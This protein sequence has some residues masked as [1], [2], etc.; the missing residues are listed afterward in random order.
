MCC[1]NAILAPGV[2]SIFCT[3]AFFLFLRYKQPTNDDCRL[4]RSHICRRMEFRDWLCCDPAL[5]LLLKHK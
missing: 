3:D 1:I 4:T 5:V 2:T